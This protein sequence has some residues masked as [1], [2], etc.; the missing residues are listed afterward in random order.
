MN[1]KDIKSILTELNFHYS[2]GYWILN[3]NNSHRIKIS[4]NKNE[5]FFYMTK[6][7]NYFDLDNDRFVFKTNEDLSSIKEK[8]VIFFDLKQ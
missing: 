5:I 2:W 4:K 6:N 3:N 7:S 8:I 1:I